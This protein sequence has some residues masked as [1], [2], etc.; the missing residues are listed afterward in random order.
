MNDTGCLA[1]SSNVF[2]LEL[3]RR[4]KAR[5]GNL[6]LSPASITTVLAM[7]WGG[8][9]GTTADRMRE[10]LHFDGPPSSVMQAW[11]RLVAELRDADQPV[12][13]RIAN[14]LFGDQVCHF[15]PAFVDAMQAA[16][17]AVLEPLDFKDD[18]EAARVRIND[19]VL[20]ETKQRIRDLVPPV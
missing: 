20:E 12:V 11:G 7:A 13:F 1:R 6:V 15:E 16:Y 17:G 14:R 19:W 10:V 8:A 5:A 18:P 9:R 4:L 2:G 3:Y